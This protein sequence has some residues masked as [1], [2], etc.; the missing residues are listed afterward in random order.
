MHPQVY[1]IPQQVQMEEGSLFGSISHAVSGVA[2]A[3]AHVATAPIKASVNVVMHPAAAINAAAHAVSS[4]KNL[5]HAIGAIANGPADLV[6]HELGNATGFRLPTPSQLTTP[7]VSAV[8]SGNLKAAL[9]EAEALGHTVA[10]ITAFVPGVGTAL[11]ATL[12]SA[13]SFL[14]H[15]FSIA[16]VLEP[17]LSVPPFSVLPPAAKDVLRQFIS[18]IVGIVEGK[19][20]SQALTDVMIKHMKDELHNKMPAPLASIGD[21]FFNAVLSIVI[22]RKPVVAAAGRLLQTAAAK[23]DPKLAATVTSSVS[24]LANFETKAATQLKGHYATLAAKSSNVAKVISVPPTT[25]H[26]MYPFALINNKWQLLGMVYSTQA[27][28]PGHAKSYMTKMHLGGMI[29]KLF[30]YTYNDKSGWD[31]GAYI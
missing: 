1:I 12:N 3:A 13:I 14:E 7:F 19:G 31:K 25:K 22:R 5:I 28:L 15:G 29:P 30:T 27:D 16:T 23:V 2:K 24:K 6:V 20:V 18:F 11:S 21:Q 26:W 9:H 8:T 4:P 17:L 10:D